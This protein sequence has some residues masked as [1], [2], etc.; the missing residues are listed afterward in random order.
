AFQSEVEAEVYLSQLSNLESTIK[1]VLNESKQISKKRKSKKQNADLDSYKRESDIKIL[2]TFP[3]IEKFS[4]VIFNFRKH[5]YLHLEPEEDPTLIQG[6]SKEF[7]AQERHRLNLKMVFDFPITDRRENHDKWID[8]RENLVF[9]IMAAH[10][11]MILEKQYPS[12]KG[13][14]NTD[15]SHPNIIDILF[16]IQNSNRKI[17]KVV[18]KNNIENIVLEQQHDV[19][20]I[21]SNVY[22]D[23]TS[24]KKLKAF[25]KQ[26]FEE[27]QIERIK[28]IF[29]ENLRLQ[30]VDQLTAFNTLFFNV[31]GCILRLD[32]KLKNYNSRNTQEEEILNCG[33]DDI[34]PLFLIEY[35]KL[36]NGVLNEKQV[37]KFDQNILQ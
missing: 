5:L 12:L 1:E 19:L 23:E 17:K 15:E 9:L 28:S 20:V 6:S 10:V 35:Q 26:F 11:K 24:I 25:Y 29:E 2:L 13:K 31:R 8:G 21:P 27:N 34:R 7:L 22:S 4:P 37:K 33:F 32:S 30:K 3:N 18:L 14:V 36:T 16:F